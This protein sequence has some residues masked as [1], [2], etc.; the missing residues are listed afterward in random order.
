MAYIA[1]EFGGKKTFG[2]YL[3]VDG[4]KQMM[5]SDGFLIKVDSGTHNLYFMNV[6]KTNRK[7]ADANFALGVLGASRTNLMTSLYMDSKMIEG[8][9][10]ETLQDN[11]LLTLTVVSDDN[12]KIL[13]MPLYRITPMTDEGMVKLDEIYQEQVKE[14]I[15]RDGSN[16]KTEFFI[17]LFLG[18][19]GIHKFY[20]GKTFVGLLYMFTLGLFL[21][22]WAIDTI[23]LLI[24][25]IKLKK[26]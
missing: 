26:S 22:G 5:L 24:K 23:V 21:F 7:I 17:C 4:D 12:G 1:I 6:P 3:S 2:G 9:I 15:Q 25:L 10:T 8:E 19:L 18:W 20:K 16:V 11:D 14:G 13:D